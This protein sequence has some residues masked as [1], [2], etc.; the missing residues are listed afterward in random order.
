MLLYLLS[1]KSDC[2]FDNIHPEKYVE[3]ILNNSLYK[4]KVSFKLNV[5]ALPAV[6]TRNIPQAVHSH[7]TVMSKYSNATF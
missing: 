3:N 6:H 1:E 5:L 4:A 2:M 7:I